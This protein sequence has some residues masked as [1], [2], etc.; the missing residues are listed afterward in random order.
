MPVTD[1]SRSKD[2]R[3]RT[4][5]EASLAE[6]D[7]ATVSKKRKQAVNEVEGG[8]SSQVTSNGQLPHFY[9][10]QCSKKRDGEL[11]IVCTYIGKT[12]CRSKYCKACLKNRYGQ[13]LEDIKTAGIPNDRKAIEGHTRTLGYIWRCPKCNDCCNCKMCR[14]KAG[15]G[16]TGNLL[17][18]AKRKGL[19][20]AADMLEQD[21]LALGV[22]RGQKLPEEE[23]TQP[24]PKLRVPKASSGVDAEGNPLPVLDK[25]AKAAADKLKEPPQP[26]W[27]EIDTELDRGQVEDRIAIREFASRFSS[28]LD[29]A[30]KYVDELDEFEIFSDSTCKALIVSLLELLSRNHDDKAISIAC[31]AIRSNGPTPLKI[32]GVLEASRDASTPASPLAGL[33]DPASPP[34]TAYRT[35][36]GHQI[37][38][39][40]QLIPVIIYLIEAA[41]TTPE[42]HDA[43]ESDAYEGKQD[44]RE[45]SRR[46]KEEKEKWS[47]TKK[48][49]T[50]ERAENEGKPGWDVEPWKTR[51]KTLEKAHKSLVW[52]IEF[53][54]YQTAPRH[55]PRFRRLGIDLDDR[56]YYALSASES[57]KLPK[58]EDRAHFRKWAWFVAVWG[59]RPGSLEFD[60]D[61]DPIEDQWWG[62]YEPKQIRKL[63]RWVGW[64]GE[65]RD[66]TQGPVGR[67][68][69]RGP[70][71]KGEEGNDAESDGT[72]GEFLSRP[73]SPLSDLS[74]SEDEGEESE[75]EQINVNLERK[76]IDLG[77]PTS[78]AEMRS[79][80]RNLL[81][82]ADWLDWRT[83]KSED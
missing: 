59:K 82:F 26:E 10:H 4:L 9:C 31:K 32:W 42:I 83:T 53:V 33:P 22:M 69:R 38:Q 73:A 27:K 67:R 61:G 25:K 63:S 60:E 52:S 39:A 1:D 2:S 76:D 37:S 58:D 68:R 80:A 78:S 23:R 7:H 75:E 29:I 18:A 57:K 21:P 19:D 45:A 16:P 14:K 47:E 50:D 72:P 79:L 77:G 55:A 36:T 74:V 62:F 15:L 81:T 56:V 24:K 8:K 66:I 12:L 49:L 43:V 6:S 13:T 46:V 54:D 17:F 64:T 51:M 41:V 5:S 71:A 40:V 30:A 34:M 28:L 3:R 70:R 65:M 35:R 20:S 48:E 44:R 11:E